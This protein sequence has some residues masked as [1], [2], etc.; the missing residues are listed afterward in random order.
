VQ[1][2][3]HSFLSSIRLRYLL[4][5]SIRAFADRLVLL[6]LVGIGPQSSLHAPLAKP[7]LPTSLASTSRLLLLLLFLGA[8]AEAAVAALVI[9]LVCTIIY[10]KKILNFQ[11]LITHTSPQ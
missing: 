8:E 9:D 3:I 2:F 6:G 1:L 10:Y 4:F 11:P 7:I 5:A